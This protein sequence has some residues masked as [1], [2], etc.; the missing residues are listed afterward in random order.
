MA[1]SSGVESSISEPSPTESSTANRF[2]AQHVTTLGSQAH[3]SAT[4][5]LAPHGSALHGSALHGSAPQGSAPHGSAAPSCVEQLSEIQLFE[6]AACRRLLRSLRLHLRLEERWLREAGVL[7]PGHRALHAEALCA[8]AGLSSVEVDRCGRL[9]L[10]RQLQHWFVQHRDGA[11]AMAYG[12]AATIRASP[13]VTVAGVAAVPSPP[14][15]S[16]PCPAPG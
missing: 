5:G 8:A 13:A 3:G 11:D 14:G 7:C 9:E 12:Q 4:H 16:L 15:S 10:L 1:Q 2:T 6:H